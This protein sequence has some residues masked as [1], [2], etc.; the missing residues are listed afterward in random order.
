ML[1]AVQSASFD[2]SSETLGLVGVPV[3]RWRP[4]A[5]RQ[6]EAGELERWSDDAS[7]DETPVSEGLSRLSRTCRDHHLRPLAC[8]QVVAEAMRL[9]WVAFDPD[10]H[11]RRRPGV[12]APDLRHVLSMPVTA[13]SGTKQEI[14]TAH[15]SAA[16]VRRNVL[17][18][19]PVVTALGMGLETENLDDVVA[20]HV[21]RHFDL[22]VTS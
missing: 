11:V 13:L 14:D 3:F 15:K 12:V 18:D 20:S 10:R 17:I 1:A 21:R 2:D 4:V 22:Y 9:D 19:L 6:F 16:T 8:R 7:A 5:R